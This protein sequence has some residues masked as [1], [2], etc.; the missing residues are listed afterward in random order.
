M[1]RSIIHSAG[2]IVI[3]IG[4]KESLGN[5]IGPLLTV[6]WP[7]GEDS[8]FWNLSWTW[9]KA[10]RWLGNIIRWNTICIVISNFWKLSFTR[11]MVHEDKKRG[12]EIGSC[13]IPLN[14]LQCA[15][16]VGFN[17]GVS[18]MHKEAHLGTWEA[19]LYT[20][21]V[22]VLQPTNRTHKRLLHKVKQF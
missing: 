14:F 19:L 20:L 2:F 4:E 8:F 3:L 22:S 18:R 16:M 12:N 13:L 7:S 11:E 10:I 6:N 15:F 5:V 17:W 21:P 9:H 1:G